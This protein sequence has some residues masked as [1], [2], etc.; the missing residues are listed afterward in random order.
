MDICDEMEAIEEVESLRLCFGF[1]IIDPVAEL[2]Y[3]LIRSLLRGVTFSSILF[4]SGGRESLLVL[5]CVGG[6]GDMI[7]FVL[8]NGDSLRDLVDLA[9]LVDDVLS[10]VL[11][12]AEMAP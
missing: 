2:V 8:S 5:R 10:G 9:D 12:D 1:G 11:R 3:E 4:E 7:V 6:G